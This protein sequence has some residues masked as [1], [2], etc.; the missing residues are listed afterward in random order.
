M[1]YAVRERGL[2]R[3]A[4]C[5][6]GRIAVAGA[7][8]YD[9]AGADRLVETHGFPPDVARHLN[10]AYGDRSPI[11]AAMAAKGFG[12][13]LHPDH[14]F[15]EAE[16]IY[17]ARHEMAMRVMDVLARRIPLVLLDRDA[18]RAASPRVADLMAGELAW[19]AERRDPEA[20]AAA[21]RLSAAL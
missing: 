15:L 18:A 6:T 19:D 4:P 16:V 21:E 12:A 20:Q 13:R 1:D 14:P 5:A 2:G 7:A 8:G 3:A 11:V 10:R 17:G 9:P